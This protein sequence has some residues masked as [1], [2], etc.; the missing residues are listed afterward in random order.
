MRHPWLINF[1]LLTLI[2]VL[3][4]CVFYSLEEEPIES[5]VLID[6]KAESVQ[7]I[8]IERE[9]KA[10][11]F[12]TKNKNGFWQMATPLHISVNAVQIE[13]LLQILSERDYKRLESDTLDLGELKLN[14]PLASIKFN[15]IT[16]AVGDT[17]PFDNRQRYVQ[18]DHNVYVIQDSFFY[19]LNNDALKFANLAPLGNSP[20]ITALK[21]PGYDLVLTEGKW[22][23]T[24]TFSETDIDG[25]ADA[26][27]QLIESWQKASAYAVSPYV[28]ST[29]SQ[30][31]IHISLQGKQQAL[32]FLI[33]SATP[34]LV[35]A[36]PITGIQYKLPANQADKLLQLPTATKPEAPPTK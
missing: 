35:L 15:Q 26:I 36:D 19:T 6:L 34:D 18:I 14:P 32:H 27:S 31:D 13:R 10:T 5:P 28:S 23:L 16:L 9:N 7:S 33:L 25:S 17:S 21:M 29:P 4:V 8:R 3:A 30:G 24:S 12:M 20:K 11:I 2:L 22:A 1:S